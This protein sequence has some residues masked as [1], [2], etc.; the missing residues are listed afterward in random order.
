MSYVQELEDGLRRLE[1]ELGASRNDTRLSNGLYA[2]AKTNIALLEGSLATKTAEVERLTGVL[3]RISGYQFELFED[4]VAAD[5][6]EQGITGLAEAYAQ[7]LKDCCEELKTVAR[8]A[9]APEGTAP[10]KEPQP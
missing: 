8:I 6:H 9:L 10:A 5:L 4:G 2:M 1:A 3:T 7:G